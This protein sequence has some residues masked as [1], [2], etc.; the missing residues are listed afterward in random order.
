MEK[1]LEG[2]PLHLAPN[3]WFHSW[4]LERSRLHGLVAEKIPDLYVVVKAVVVHVRFFERERGLQA[5]LTL[6]GA[7]ACV[8][9][10][11]LHT[12]VGVCFEFAF[13]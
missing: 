3:V 7:G 6:R 5:S 4:K 13:V 9:S 10:K 12:P 8:F 2:K 11:L 1:K